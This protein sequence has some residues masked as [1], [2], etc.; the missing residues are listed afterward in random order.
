MLHII[1][2]IDSLLPSAH[3]QLPS[4]EPGEEGGPPEPASMG[5]GAVR[6]ALG[7][8]LGRGGYMLLVILALQYTL[9][10]T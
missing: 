5:P 1:F 6:G 4:A 3:C 2:P 8:G 9:S 7:M 10:T